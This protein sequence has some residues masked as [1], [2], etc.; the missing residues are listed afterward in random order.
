MPFPGLWG[1]CDGDTVTVW[2][3]V[4]VLVLVDTVVLVLVLVLGVVV[5]VVVGLSVVVV[6]GLSVVV[7]VLGCSVWVTVCVPS[8]G[9]GATEACDE[10]DDAVVL[11]VV[12]VELEPSPPVSETIA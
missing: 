9:T 8:V 4:L 2:V 7:V 5:V 1:A 11:E 6:V 3:T 10:V 12:D